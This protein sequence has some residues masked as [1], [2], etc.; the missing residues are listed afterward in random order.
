MGAKIGYGGG[1]DEDERFR[2]NPVADTR[3]TCGAS[4]MVGRTKFYCEKSG[5]HEGKH[6]H[7]G[8]SE[9]SSGV[10]WELTW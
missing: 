10:K 8:T 7:Q 5:R 1:N 4:C 3:L 2:K 6:E 9:G